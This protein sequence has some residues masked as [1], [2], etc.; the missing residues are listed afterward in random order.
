MKIIQIEYTYIVV[1]YITVFISLVRYL[2]NYYHNIIERH[3]T[4]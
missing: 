2:L 4:Y 3:T 1:N